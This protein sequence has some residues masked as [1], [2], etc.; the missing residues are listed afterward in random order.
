[1]VEFKIAKG[2]R[3]TG[4][5][6]AGML[7]ARGIELNIR[8]FGRKNK[9]E[10]GGAAVI[11]WGI[12]GSDNRPTLNAKAN[13]SKYEQ[14][15]KLEAKGV[16]VPKATLLLAG[17]S[18]ADLAFPK[19]ARK[20][21]HAGG[22]DIIVIKE[23]RD[24]FKLL[25]RDYAY[26]TE[27]VPSDREF[28]VWIF[29][30]RHLVTY[31]KIKKREAEQPGFGRNYAQGY[32]FDRIENELV[33]DA[34]KQIGRNAISALE[35]DFGAA[36]VLLGTDGRYYVLEVN[37]APRIENERRTCGLRLVKQIEKWVATGFP[38]RAQ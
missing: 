1:M 33:P 10:P 8:A 24:L 20:D 25:N 11:N 38:A 26:F 29:R 23:A 21:R 36:D 15:K 35:L 3:P 22:T 17:W 19:L 32:G 34:L 2:G 12:S 13:G 6:I 30:E 16:L 14:L 4:K 7:Q 37:T 5:M 18:G 9:G 28:R 27:L 31:E